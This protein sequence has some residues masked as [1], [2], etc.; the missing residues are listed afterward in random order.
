MKMENYLSHTDYPIWQVIH[1]GNG[2]VSVTTDT[3][4]MIKVLPPK[5]AEEVV[6]RERER[7]ARTT[8]LMALPEDHL[9][10]FYKMADAKEIQLEIHG[11]GVSHE[12]ANQ[13][14]LRSLP[15]F[16]SQV[17][18]IM[19]TKPGLNTLSFDDLYNNLR[20]FEH[21]VKGTTASSS[22]NTPN[23]AFVS[24]DNTN[25]V[26]TAYSVSSPSVSKSQK[27]GSSSYTDEVIH[28]FFANQSSAPQLDYD[29]L[30]QINDDDM[31]EV[32]LKWQMPMISMRI[33]KFHKRTSK[34]L[35]FDT[36]DPV[37]F[38][39]TKVE[40]F[41]C[42]K[43]GHFARYCRAKGNQNNRRRDAGY[44]G[45][46]ARDNEALKEKEDLKTKFKNWQNSSKNLSR[47]LNTQISANDK[48]GLGYEDYRYGTILS[49]ENEVL[50]SVFMNKESDLEH[51]PIN[52]RYT[53]GMH[54]VP[55]LMAGNYMPFRPDV[56]IDYSKFTYG[57]KQTSVDELD[58]KTSVSTS[59][60]SDSSVE[61][62]TSM[63]APV[64]N[65][66]KVVCEPKVWTDAPIIEEYESD[67]DDDSVSNVQEDKEKSS[68]AFTNSVKHVRTSRENVKETDTP[69]HCPK[70]EKQDRKGPTRKSLDYA[71][72]R[73]SC[74]VCGSFRHL[75]RDCDFYEKRMVKQAELT[76]SKNKVTG[77]TENRPIWNNL[78]RVNHQNKFVPSVVLTKTGKFLV[79]AARQNYTSQA[80]S[81]S[82]ANK[83]NTARSFM[84]ETRTKR[85]HLADYQE[86]KGGSIA[87]GGSN[88]RITGK[89]KIHANRLDFEDIYYVK[90]LK[91]YNLFSVSQMCDKKNKVLFTDTDCLVLSPD[92]KLPDENQVLLKIPRQHNMYSFNLKNIHPSG[93]L[94]CL[95]AKALIDESNKWH[96][97]L[98]Y[99][100]EKNTDFQ[101]CEKPV[102]QVEQIFQEELKKLKRQEK[103][104]NDA[105]RKEATHENQDAN[106]NSTNLLN[107]VSSPIST[108]GPSRAL[109]NGEASYPDDPS[110]PHLEDIYASPSEGIFTDSSYDDEGVTRSKVNK[111]S[112]AHAL[113]K[114]QKVWILVD[115]PFGKKAIETKWVYMNKK[116]ERG[117]V[118]RNKARLVAQGHRQE[119]GIDYEEVFALV[120]RIE[121]IR[122]FLAFA[123][124]MGFIVY[125]MD[126][127]SA[128]MYDPKFPS[129]V[130]KVVKALY[131]L[132]QAPRAWYATLSTFLEK[133]GYRRG[134]IDNTLFIKQD[135][136]DIMLVQVY[137]DDII[138][139]STKKSWCDEFEELMKNRFQMSSMGEL[140][141][142]LGLQV[143]QK[144]DG[145]FISQY[146][147]VA[148]ILKKFDFLSVK[149]FSTPIETHKPLVKDEE[150][151][152][153][154]V[155]LYRSMIGSLMYLTASR[156]DVMFA[157]CACSR[158]QVTPKTSHLQ[159]VKGIFRKST[160]GGCQFLGRRLILWQCKKQTIVATS[161]T[162]AEYNP[163]FL[164]KTKHIE[165][166]HYFIMDAYEK[167]LIQV[168]KIHTNDNV[169]DLLTKAFDVTSKEL[170]SPKQT[171][172]G[173]D[174][175]NPLIV[176]SLLKTIWLSMH[177]VIAMKLWLFQSK[178]L[179]ATAS[180]KKVNDMVKLRAL[181][182]G[183]RV[184]VTEDVIRHDLR[185]DDA[186]GVECLPNEEIF[187]EL[188]RMSYEKPPPK[189]TFYKAFFSAQWKFLIHT[190]YTSP[191]LTQKVFTDMRR[192]GKRFLGVETPLF[193]TMLVQPQAEVEEDDVERVKKLENKRRSKSSGLHRLRKVGTSQR[194]EFST[195]AVVGAQED[196][197]KQG[198]ELRR[199]KDD[200][201]AA[202]K[203]ASAAEPTVFDDEEVTMT[204]AQTLIKMKAKK[205]RLLDEQMAKRLHDEEVEQ[206]AT[207]EKQ[208]K[209][210]LEKAKVLQKQK[211]QSLKIKPIYV[212][213]ARKNMIVY[214]KNMARYKMEYFKVEVLGSHSTQDTL[215]VDPK[216][217]SEEDVKNMLEIVLVTEFKVEALQVK[218]GGIT[219]AYQSFKDMLK[220]F[221]REDLDVLWR[222]VK[223]KFS[224]AVHTVDKEKA[225]WVELKR[226]F[227]P[228]SNDVIWKLQRYMHYP[229][230][231]KLHSNCGVHQV[232]STTK[233]HDMYMLTWKDYP[234]SSGV[235]NLMMSTRLQVEE[236]N[237][238]AR[239][240]VMKIFMKTNQP[241]S[242]SLDTSSK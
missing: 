43:I 147:Y 119:E 22:S 10:K 34:K 62:T 116:D 60:E 189:L 106:T 122:I 146:K 170:A 139:G 192:V 95:F 24:F 137:V 69:N 227:K 86:I 40:C 242:R 233:R 194:V 14:F 132:H 118:V 44:N 160:T 236:D 222:L 87:F 171:A 104:A 39:K 182:D 185:L 48:F 74:F 155:H 130:Y 16:W 150:A 218:V 215:T 88:G 98:G 142:F 90:E 220:D 240:L 109:N 45:N 205:A 105:A 125:Q 238:M 204:M 32:D 153:V 112:E 49:Y 133:S 63:P 213:Q 68:F 198:G 53:E 201:N 187:T 217:M 228:D 191:A 111:N 15:S 96:R 110:M 145:I 232:S 200:D 89:G 159:A 73:K 186:D 199:R 129:K 51:T 29:D 156:P 55:P 163:V 65:T 94:A 103:K 178:Q 195:E 207:R 239:D 231:W 35:Q 6:S 9:A 223:E 36:K 61:T 206:A 79:N 176:D 184:V 70:V 235:M 144:E 154:D 33:K 164:S 99:K 196:A 165:I 57:P 37:G 84:N 21:D 97:R 81:T 82:A 67:S 91:H 127:K 157:V 20:V 5:T 11:A 2:P 3:N 102:S 181:V 237:E 23:V 211:Y 168:L 229:I 203:D 42:H 120:A 214:L 113:F 140:A 151:A 190:L 76:K 77:Q 161:T 30:E 114:I 219:Q 241:K 209:E 117:V 141:F 174:E 27:E 183:K 210:D 80:A 124:Y 93:D 8:L 108:A 41:N 31:E 19:R 26:S 173:K 138:F 92:F 59:C 46:K 123:S 216:E 134:A 162:K 7:K 166:R 56:E 180:I 224:S 107:D 188:A 72:T 78:Q 169:A 197:S 135:K 225:L 121:A 115:L 47:L 58:A 50:Q 28:S 212:A 126:V 66:P 100:I 177:H 128:F 38:D 234:L 172:L 143:K 54:A 17:A 25:D 221:D 64:D 193:A 148:K 101:T 12:N 83:V 179:L 167:K 4:G 85:S 136:K 1:N 131:G 226:L 13:K 202:I 230:T 149:T 175:S 152:D 158:F 52:D 71:F 208:E 75:I 18:L